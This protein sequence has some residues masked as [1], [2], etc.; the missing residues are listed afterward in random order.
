MKAFSIPLLSL[1]LLF[2][3]CSNPSKQTVA[4][5]DTSKKIIDTNH[6]I[7]VSMIQLI[8]NPKKYEGYTVRVH[9]YLH[10]EFEGNGLYFHKEDYERSIEK[11]ALWVSVY[12]DEGIGLEAIKCNN[13][14]VLIEGTFSTKQGHM[15]MYSG[16]LEN[17]KRV[18]IWE[19]MNIP[20][21]PKKDQVNFPASTN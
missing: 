21:K 18:E 8:A 16:S 6:I 11:N 19:N 17:I 15:S 7:D 4:V 13:H 20:P 14:H 12:P 1:I 5:T 3:Y 2:A 10:L 9:G